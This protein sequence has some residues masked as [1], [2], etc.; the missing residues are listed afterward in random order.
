MPR[1]TK[2][3]QNTQS[4][5]FL[6]KASEIASYYGFEHIINKL[7]DI[8]NQESPD[9]P[10]KLIRLVQK[11]NVE[12]YKMRSSEFEDSCVDMAEIYYENKLDL[13]PFPFLTYYSNGDSK[14]ALPVK[15]KTKK[16]ETPCFTM[17]VVGVNKHVSESILLK[18]ALIILG[19][20][21]F[22]GFKIALNSM[23]D[24]NSATSF[25][26][27]LSTHIKNNLHIFHARCR[28]CFK[29]DTL[30]AFECIKQE[31]P[32]LMPSIPKPIQFLNESSRN[33][34]RHIIEHLDMENV[35]YELDDSLVGPKDFYNETVFEI[36][37]KNEEDEE[38]VLA[39]GGRYNNFF[40]KY[41]D[42][43]IPAIGIT[44]KA[45]PSKETLKSAPVIN[46]KKN[47]L[48]VYLLQIGFEARIKSFSLLESL[49]RAGISIAQSII[50]EKIDHQVKDL[51]KLNIEYLIIIGQKE[52]LEGVAIIRKIETQA[53]EIVNIEDV[54]DI[55]KRRKL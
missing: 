23:G 30:E 25:E 9:A 4:E 16:K 13:L 2:K 26:E 35:T 15:R 5:E 6:R 32:M 49:R 12:K 19:D 8:K 18:T 38:E 34:L 31:S 39:V 14:N 41:L 52:A 21:G 29:K 48:N 37:R 54:V 43:E 1:Q 27:E 10:E 46:N 11:N 51:E 17:Q 24:E 47:K 33:H 45:K 44:I 20:A 7:E 40:K 50:N 55:L 22:D 36:R 53:Q 3:R 42:A 28:Q